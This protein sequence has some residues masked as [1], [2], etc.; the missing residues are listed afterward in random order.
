L[1]NEGKREREREREREKEREKERRIKRETYIEIPKTEREDNLECQISGSKVV[2][3]NVGSTIVWRHI[4]S[5]LADT[6][7]CQMSVRP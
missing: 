1:K 4:G 3:P 6:N 2:L 7:H 5:L